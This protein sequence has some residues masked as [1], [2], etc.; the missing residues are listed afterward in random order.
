MFSPHEHPPD[1]REEQDVPERQR[2]GHF[3]HVAHMNMF[4][5]ETPTF[6]IPA[7]ISFLK[8][9]VEEED[10][11]GLGDKKINASDPAREVDICSKLIDQV[12][13]D[14]HL[15]DGGD[16][17]G[18]ETS[19]TSGS[20]AKERRSSKGSQEDNVDE[21]V[22]WAKAKGKVE[23]FLDFPGVIA[24]LE[25]R[26]QSKAPGSAQS[27]SNNGRGP[28]SPG[29]TDSMLN[30]RHNAVFLRDNEKAAEAALM[31][32]HYQKSNRPRATDSA[33]S[34]TKSPDHGAK[35]VERASSLVDSVAPKS[36]TGTDR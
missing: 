19:P 9:S 30:T 36:D 5:S 34:T 6:R 4:S 27:P 1:L 28:V 35:M 24:A 23:K 20:S 31:T 26:K 15:I 18:P 13:L 14:V 21:D 32:A 11:A 22:E 33:G 8:L 17:D 2:A 16:R 10:P 25:Y 3:E 7:K 29:H 12:K